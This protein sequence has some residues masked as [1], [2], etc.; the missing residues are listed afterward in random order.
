[1]A[2]FVPCAPVEVTA[3]VRAPAIYA[4][5]L[6]GPLGG[7]LVSPMLGEIGTSLHTSAGAAATS[8]TA[9]FVPFAVVQFVSGTLGERWGRR[10]TVRAAYVVYAVTSALC[11]VAWN[12]PLFLVLR[13][14]MGTANAFTSPLLLAGLTDLVRPER[15]SHAIGVFA[16]AQAAGQSFAPLIGGLAAP[17]SWRYA[18]A[19]VAITAAGLA[20]APPPGEPRPGASAPPWRPLVSTRMALLS[21]IGLVSYLGAAG[22]PFLVALHTENDLHVS[23][24]VAG[25]VLLAFGLAGLLLGT[26]WGGVSQRIGPTRAGIIAAVIAAVAVAVVGV[27]TSVVAVAVVWAV[28]GAAVALMTVALQNL[29]V[30]AVPA[31][32]GGALSVVSA[33]RFGGAA[34]APV[35]WVSAYHSAPALAFALAGAVLL[36]AVPAF[37]GTA[38]PPRSTEL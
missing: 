16:S 5:G 34:L 22:L 8:L 1:M 9:Y 3:D 32:R 25:A 24:T 27:V 38:T 15:L 23:T 36:L 18:F 2:G 6:L 7:G 13:A 26:V 19:A 33:F 30:R 21:L 10:R 20:I 35:V 14:L 11:V 12:L 37:Y 29:S 4:G 31:N 28:A 17:V